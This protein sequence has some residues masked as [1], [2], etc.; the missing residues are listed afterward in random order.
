MSGGGLV[1]TEFSGSG[2]WL[3]VTLSDVITMFCGCGFV[4]SSCVLSGGDVIGAV[5]VGNELVRIGGW[6]SF[7][8]SDVVLR[9][10]SCVFSS[11]ILWAFAVGTFSLLGVA[12]EDSSL[13]DNRRRL[14][15]RALMLVPV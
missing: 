13:W 7:V 2:I 5:L 10:D 4:V 12:K 11:I 6:L 14:S 15:F 3:L 9:F 1:G 8:S